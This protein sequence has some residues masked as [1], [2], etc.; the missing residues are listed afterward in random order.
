MGPDLTNIGKT[1]TREQILEA[2]VM[3]SERLAP[4]YGSVLITL[5]DGQE[6]SGILMSDLEDELILKTS[7]AEP[8]EISKARIARR[9]NMPSGMPPMGLILQKKEIRDL[10]EFL[11]RQGS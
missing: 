3:P 10:V 5:K 8:M 1:L 6:I 2:L 11:S 9:E 4:G 7:E